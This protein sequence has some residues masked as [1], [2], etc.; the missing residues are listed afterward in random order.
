MTE[1]QAGFGVPAGWQVFVEESHSL[2]PAERHGWRDFPREA[3]DL[4]LHSTL[5]SLSSGLFLIT[6][7][8]LLQLGMIK[9][10]WCNEEV[11]DKRNI[12]SNIFGGRRLNRLILW[13]D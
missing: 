5:V 6:N 10:V 9:E 8:A 11:R 4:Y 7:D 1:M 2:P 3:T 13:N 12:I